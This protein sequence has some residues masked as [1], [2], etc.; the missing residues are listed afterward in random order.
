MFMEGSWSLLGALEN[1]PG[2]DGK[3]DIAKL[4][5]APNPVHTDESLDTG[6]RACMSN[7]LCY[8]TAAH[9]KRLDTVLDVL[10]FFG[11]EEAQNI[12]SSYGAAISAYIGT[13]QPY[14][15]ASS[16][17]TTR[18]GPSGRALSSTS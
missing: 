9:G 4:P 13:E 3:W 2:M 17:S 15:D 6:G 12:A 7:G 5:K 14:F 16:A 18:P 8:A 1:N 10:K 11:T